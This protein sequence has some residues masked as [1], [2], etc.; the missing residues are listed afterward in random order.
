MERLRIDGIDLPRIY[1]CSTRLDVERCRSA[2]IPYIAWR[3]SHLTLVKHMLLPALQRQFPSIK[4]EKVLGIGRRGG[5]RLQVVDVAGGQAEPTGGDGDSMT[6]DSATSERTFGGDGAQGLQHTSA[7]LVDYV[8]ADDIHVDMDVLQR[9]GLLPDFMDDIATCIR[10]NLTGYA[11]RECYNKRLGA[12]VGDY[13]VGNAKGNLMILDI[14]GSIP[15]GVSSTMLALIDTLRGN[16]DA[17]LI[18]TAGISTW[19][20]AG[21]ELPSPERLR[22]DHPLG[23]ESEMFRN[24]VREHVAGRGWGNVICF[25]DFDRPRA[26]LPAELKGCT[27]DALWGYHTRCDSVPGY[28]EWAEGI[29]KETHL[30]H[31]W[32]NNMFTNARW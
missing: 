27:V 15:R 20:P 23:N 8:C 31:A 25:G 4:W 10:R 9:L 1:V 18:V 17:D 11:W 2:G 5:D 13:N 14:S 12:C 22:Q 28:A 24:L 7:K 16:A 29:A 19:W 3:G 21:C 30:D 32:V 26:F 6:A